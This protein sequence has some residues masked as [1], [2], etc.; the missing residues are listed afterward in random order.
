MVAVNTGKLR[1]ETAQDEKGDSKATRSGV[2]K[3]VE[4]KKSS[5]KAIATGREALMMASIGGDGNNVGGWDNVGG[6]GDDVPPAVGWDE[7]ERAEES[8]Q[9]EPREEPRAKKKKKRKALS[10]EPDDGL[11]EPEP[12]S[13]EVK[14][15]KKKK[16]L[17][18]KKLK[19][20][21]PDSLGKKKK[22]KVLFFD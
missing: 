10:P 21:T 19:A 9:E 18:G 12:E 2:V 4:V 8:E 11:D 1:G 3:I 22:K 20:K 6:W 7:P 17:D 13:V 5:K 15:K 16:S 14:K